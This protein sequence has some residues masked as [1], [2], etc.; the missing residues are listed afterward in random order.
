MAQEGG[1]IFVV[2]VTRELIESWVLT[3]SEISARCLKGLPLGAR[4]VAAS[5]EDERVVVLDFAVETPGNTTI[6]EFNP[7]YERV[8]AP[9]VTRGDI[10]YVRDAITDLRKADIAGWPI[11]ES[12]L[13]ALADRIEAALPPDP[14][15]RKDMKAE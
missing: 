7:I 5:F 13:G 15:K 14:P 9:H 11:Y 8:L 1:M 10:M 2:R 6:T 12:Q 4:L 3:G